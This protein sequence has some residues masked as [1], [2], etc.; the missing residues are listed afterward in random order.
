[1]AMTEKEIAYH[2]AGHIAVALYFG[3]KFRY[4][5]LNGKDSF[6]RFYKRKVFE[7]MKNGLPLSKREKKFLA[8]DIQVTYA[9]G[10]VNGYLISGKFSSMV[11]FSQDGDSS[12]IQQILHAAFPTGAWDEDYDI[13]F[14]QKTEEILNELWDL[15]CSIGNLL[16]DREK[17][18][19]KECIK[20][21]NQFLTTKA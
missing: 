17:L 11:D 18:S 20:V 1:M 10:M 16:L 12:H 19:Y 7:K 6:V 5:V 15:V 3:H 21:Y 4:A 14:E 13:Y 2:E 8:E 9:G